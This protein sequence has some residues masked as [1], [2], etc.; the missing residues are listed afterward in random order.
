MRPL[1]FASFRSD[2]VFGASC[3]R[4]LVAADR[5]ADQR[6]ALRDPAAVAI[7]VQHL[8]ETLGPERRKQTTLGETVGG[9]GVRH[10]E[11]IGAGTSG[12]D[13]LLQPAEHRLTAAAQE[14][15]LD[16][17]FLLELAGKL[18]RQRD[19]RRGVPAQRAFALGG[20][21]I[22]VVRGEGLTVRDGCEHDDREN[23]TA[24]MPPHD[25]FLR[26]PNGFCLWSAGHVAKAI[27]RSD[28]AG[29]LQTQRSLKAAIA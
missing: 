24:E 10:G 3:A 19:R 17:G 4:H 21:G 7:L 22:G 13:L 6:Q 9:A 5:D 29:P 18:L 1:Y 16:A 15:N 20:V 12:A 25:R 27:V 26:R 28:A 23:R 11:H 2:Q 8:V 14:L